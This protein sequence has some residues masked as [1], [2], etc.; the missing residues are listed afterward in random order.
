MTEKTE[1]ER[2]THTHTCVSV[3]HFHHSTS[4]VPTCVYLR[5]QCVHLLQEFIAWANLAQD[6]QQT[7]EGGKSKT[8]AAVR[9]VS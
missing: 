8:V 6:A 2:H 7:L 4:F 3:F 5:G 1:R 9:V